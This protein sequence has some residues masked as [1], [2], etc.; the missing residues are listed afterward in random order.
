MKEKRH[1]LSDM[2]CATLLDMLRDC[3]NS[4]PNRDLLD[5]PA[6]YYYQQALALL[7][8]SNVWKDNANVQQW[9]SNN[10]LCSPNVRLLTREEGS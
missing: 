10:W 6:D 9:L 1:G 2:D 7:K 4:P 5:M 3:A 8:S